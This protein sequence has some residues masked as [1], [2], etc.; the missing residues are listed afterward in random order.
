MMG[1]FAY[2]LCLIRELEL[3]LKRPLTTVKFTAYKVFTFAL[4]ENSNERLYPKLAR[5]FKD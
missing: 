3:V 5:I 4:K 2:D 1:G